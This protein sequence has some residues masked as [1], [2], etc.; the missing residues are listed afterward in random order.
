[1]LRDQANSDAK[2][3][4]N[5]FRK[6]RKNVPMIYGKYENHKK[7]CEILHLYICLPACRPVV[8]SVCASFVGFYHVI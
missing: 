1:M 5:S 6:A 8:E 4:H 3:Y 7:L 2:S